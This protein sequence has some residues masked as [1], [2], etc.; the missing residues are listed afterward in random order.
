MDNLDD[1][2]IFLIE[3]KLPKGN[4]FT[5]PEGYF[6][7]LGEH[8]E[9]RINVKDFE[10]KTNPFALPANYFENLE[11]RIESR[12]IQIDSNENVTDDFFEIQK[13]QILNSI[14][15]IEKAG[16]KSPFEVPSGYFENVITA[17]E[18][19]TSL[20]Q[21]PA[22]KRFKTMRWAYAAAAAI[23]LSLGVVY[24]SNNRPVETMA[25]TNFNTDSLSTSEIVN[26][27]EKS[28][29]PDEELIKHIDVKELTNLAKEQIQPDDKE[30]KS[31]LYEI[32]ENELTKD[33]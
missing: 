15:L 4:P 29:I 21:R 2:N 12:I 10:V 5:L 1:N 18:S 22:I 3:E 31:I 20:K 23:I 19:K 25:I 32:D 6:L 30:L 24:F 26:K 8:I 17:I 13:E 16:N 14:A 11:Q 27:L 33:M 28:D 7:S 9:N